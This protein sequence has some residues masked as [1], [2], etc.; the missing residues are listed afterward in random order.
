MSAARTTIDTVL[1]RGF[2]T[3]W[4]RRLSTGIQIAPHLNL[5]NDPK[6]QVASLR[7]GCSTRIF[8]GVHDNPGPFELY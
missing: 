5:A 3:A 1:Q 6:R 2:V 8:L 4:T 7:K